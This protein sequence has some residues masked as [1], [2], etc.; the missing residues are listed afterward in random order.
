MISARSSRSPGLDI[1]ALTTEIS[2]RFLVALTLFQ[3]LAFSRAQQCY[4][5]G[6]AAI[7][8]DV[9]RPEGITCLARQTFRN[10]PDVQKNNLKWSAIDYRGARSSVAFVLQRFPIPQ[11]SAADLVLA[12]ELYDATGASLRSNGD[13]NNVKLIK[14]A[15]FCL[16]MQLGL[17]NKNDQAARR[18]LNKTIKNCAKCGN[19]EKAALAAIDNAL[20]SRGA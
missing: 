2:L 16:A 12:S 3:F 8:K 13:I 17:L 20:K 10:V 19:A 11:T 5:T 6:G 7:P 9:V 14:G 1:M 18:N 15:Q 4:I